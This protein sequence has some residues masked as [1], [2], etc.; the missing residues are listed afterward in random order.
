MTR[1]HT[2]RNEAERY[3]IERFHTTR[4]DIH[5]IYVRKEIYC[6]G[7]K[8]YENTSHQKNEALEDIMQNDVTQEGYQKERHPTGGTSH[9]KDIT[10]RKMSHGR[11]IT[12]KRRHTGNF[13]ANRY[14]TEKLSHT[15]I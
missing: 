2:V 7:L 8:P 11:N 13:H 10:Y 6:T 9:M 4:H 1:H 12:Q 5:Y 14:Q 15:R 3:H